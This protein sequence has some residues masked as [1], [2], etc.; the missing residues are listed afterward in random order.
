MLKMN[1]PLI[2]YIRFWAYNSFLAFG[3]GFVMGYFFQGLLIFLYPPITFP[4]AFL[5]VYQFIIGSFFWGSRRGAF[6][7]SYLEK[8]AAINKFNP[9]LAEALE[10]VKFE[11]KMGDPKSAMLKLKEAAQVHKSNFAVHFKLA[12][13]CEKVGLGDEA[14]EAYREALAIV[15]NNAQTLHDYVKQQIERVREK[16]PQKKSTA[17]GLNRVLY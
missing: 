14:I 1:I 3:T 17:P 11:Y 13:A 6:E 4:F 8:T 10:K 12:I 5:L 2:H 9:G 15:P 16:G 7:Y